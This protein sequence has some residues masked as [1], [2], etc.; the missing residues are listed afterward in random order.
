MT[1]DG[2]N[3]MT[4]SRVEKIIDNIGFVNGKEDCS[5]KNTCLYRE[6]TKYKS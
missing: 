2:I 1:L 4:K 5:R 6:K 3:V